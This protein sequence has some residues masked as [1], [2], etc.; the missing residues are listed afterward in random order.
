M[1]KRT[2]SHL[3]RAQ[4]T[5]TLLMIEKESRRRR[6]GGECQMEARAEEIIP[7]S[8]FVQGLAIGWSRFALRIVEEVD[9][10]READFHPIESDCA[11][12]E[13]EAASAEEC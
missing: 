12:E 10:M 7:R 1:L 11:K 13:E 5:V 6:R 2:E 3:N 4:R 9:Q 8:C